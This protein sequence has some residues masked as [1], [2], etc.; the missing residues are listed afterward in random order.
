MANQNIHIISLNVRGLRDATKRRNVIQWLKSKNPDIVFLQETHCHLKKDVNQWNKE[1][2]GS[3]LHNYWTM[4]NSR[5]KGV[6]ILFSKRFCERD[7]DVTDVLIDPNGRSVKLVLKINGRNYRLIN[8]YAPNNEVERVRF[9]SDL[10]NLVKDDVDADTLLGGDFNCTM[11]SI[12]DRQNCSTKNDIGQID[13]QYLSNTYDLEDIWRRRN[14][15]ERGFTWSGREKMSRIDFWLTS[16]SL[17]NQIDDVFHT[18][19]PYTDHK[20]ISIILKMD[21]IPQGPGIWKMNTFNILQDDFKQSFQQM[22]TQWQ[23]NKH[24][25]QDI[26]IWWDV[27]KRKIKTLTQTFSKKLSTNVT[28]S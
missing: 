10:Q 11:D 20:S 25:Y 13:L 26:R 4:G 8:I 27:G 17:D 5:S 23:T 1:W 3:K 12:M 14:P 16:L 6:A 7:F 2:A 15:T 22:W 9:F 28:L 19:A 21:E 24:N 18:Y